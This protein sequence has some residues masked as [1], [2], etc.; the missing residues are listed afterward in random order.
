VGVQVIDY[1]SD[2]RGVCKVF[3]DEPTD[4]L[5]E[6]PFGV[7]VGH[8][9]MP[10]ATGRTEDDKEAFGPTVLVLIVVARCPAGSWWDRRKHIP[11]E[12]VLA[13]IQA[14]DRSASIVGLGIQ[15]QHIL[16]GSD[17]GSSH[18]RQTPLFMTLW[19]E[20]IFFQH[21]P[22]GFGRDVFDVPQLDRLLSEQP[23][24]PVVVTV[25]GG[26]AHNGDQMCG[27]LR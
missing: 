16:H 12:L 1:Q 4:H 17:K 10:P 18:P 11:Q 19:L 7:M 23:E 25:R 13:F 22:D 27:L 6:V 5:R 15:V 3:I 21:L 2:H 8:D 26:G 14:D 20:L 9:H 24:G